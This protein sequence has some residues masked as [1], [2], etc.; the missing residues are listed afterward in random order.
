VRIKRSLASEMRVS[1]SRRLAQSQP[2]PRSKVEITSPHASAIV[3]R[4]A[5]LGSA[6][7]R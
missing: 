7:K 5:Q 6:T 1:R 3:R 2:P 4:T